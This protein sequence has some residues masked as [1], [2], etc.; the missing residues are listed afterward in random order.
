MERAVFV[1]DV[2]PVAE[3]GGLR[4]GLLAACR[5]TGRPGGAAWTTMQKANVGTGTRA[6]ARST[7]RRTG[8]HL[9]PM[10]FGLVMT[11]PSQ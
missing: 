2:Q 4:P 6:A 3:V 1:D 7:T 11:A 8:V 10:I 9:W 5:R